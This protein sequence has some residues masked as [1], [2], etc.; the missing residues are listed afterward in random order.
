[1]N[2]AIALSIQQPLKRPLKHDNG[3][4]NEDLYYK[5]CTVKS[6]EMY[7]FGKVEVLSNKSF[8]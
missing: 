8:F 1:M 2:I 5:L 7:S 6:T 4:Q 3:S